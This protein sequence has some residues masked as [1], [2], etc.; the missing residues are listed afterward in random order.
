MGINGTGTLRGKDAIRV[1]WQAALERIPDL[2]FSLRGVF[3]GASSVVIHY[4]GP[5]GIGAEVF[6]FNADGKVIR[7]FANYDS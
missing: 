4:D 1:Y 6:E 7:A 2:Q 5:R 3:C